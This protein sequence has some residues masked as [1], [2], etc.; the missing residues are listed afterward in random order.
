MYVGETF[1]GNVTYSAGENVYE[2]PCKGAVGNTVKVV[3]Y[4]SVLT[5]CEVEA[6]GTL[7]DTSDT[8]PCKYQGCKRIFMSLTD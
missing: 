6:W 2:V 3:T 1:C 5:L 7:E 4:G 8:G